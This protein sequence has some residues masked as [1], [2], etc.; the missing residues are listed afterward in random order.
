MKEALLAAALFAAAYFAFR[1]LALKRALKEAARELA[2]LEEDLS[3]NR[4]LHLPM[5][6]AALESFIKAV[7]ACL[8]KIRRERCQYEQREREFQQQIEN[9]SHDLRTPL[10]VILGYLRLMKESGAGAESLEVIERNAQALERLVG[11][12]YMYSQLNA[13]EYALTPMSLDIGRLLRESLL[14]NEQLLSQ[15]DLDVT[16]KL[17]EGPVMAWGDAQ[18]LERV[19]ANLFQNAGRYAYSELSVGL[20][21]QEDGVEISFINDTE[22][23]SP[24]EALQLFERF[25]RRDP[26]RSQSGS[27]LGLTVA[28]GLAEAMGGRLTAECSQAAGKAVKAGAECT[29]NQLCLRLWLGRGQ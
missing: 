13:Q 22:R 2:E 18:A 17:P 27:G 11:Q 9:I 6:D 29:K 16:C 20:E 28:K 7:N 19:F 26:A 3:Q 8:A 1:G 24:E 10:T 21:E 15:A 5:P 12:F 23:L 4:F 25:Y 14:A